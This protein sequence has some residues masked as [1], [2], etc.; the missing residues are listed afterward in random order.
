VVELD[1]AQAAA[2]GAV[3]A[4]R[5]RGRRGLGAELAR[6]TGRSRSTVGYWLKGTHPV[7]PDLLPAVAAVLGTTPEELLAAAAAVA[8]AATARELSAS[9]LSDTLPPALSSASTAG[10]CWYDAYPLWGRDDPRGRGAAGPGSGG[11]SVVMREQSGALGGPADVFA[12][13]VGDDGLAEIDTTIGRV[14]AGFRLFVDTRLADAARP[15]AIVAGMSA[16][17]RLMVGA[18]EHHPG[19]TWSLFTGAHREGIDRADVLGEV[20]EYQSPPAA[21]GHIRGAG[22][23]AETF[24]VAGGPEGVPAKAG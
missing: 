9:G 18:L 4:E 16:T 8:A 7:P 2:L 23:A 13:L 17:G 12:V 3:I 22:G 6:R 15:G 21:I 24:F 20:V 5:A 14:R 1:R 19:D 11:G 10:V